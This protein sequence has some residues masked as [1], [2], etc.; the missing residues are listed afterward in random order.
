MLN[1]EMNKTN[2]VR[3]KEGRT[4]LVVQWLRLC[5]SNAE[6]MGSIP[7]RGTKI[8]NGTWCSQKLNKL[9]KKGREKRRKGKNRQA[10]FLSQ[11][12]KLCP[13]FQISE[14]VLVETQPSGRSRNK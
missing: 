9:K 7:G 4:S 1:S 8:P 12:E 6:G 2:L 11:M 3:K 5:P 14:L 13:A 10:P